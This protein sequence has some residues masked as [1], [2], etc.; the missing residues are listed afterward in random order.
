MFR[1]FS[2]SLLL[3]AFVSPESSA[4]VLRVGSWN[5]ANEPN[6]LERIA[7]FETVLSA[8]GEHSV[9]GNS[10]RLSILALQE[11]DTDSA[12]DVRDSFNAMY[13]GSTY[14]TIFSNPDGGGDRTGFIYDSSLVSL[15][16]QSEL[17]DSLTHNVLRA[18]F[19]P[20]ALGTVEPLTVYSIHLKSGASSADRVIRGSEAQFIRADA[21]FLGPAASILFTGD[22]NM[23]SSSEAAWDNLTS[24][25]NA[26]A[27]DLADS[28]G[29]W[30]DNPNFSWLHTQAPGT[31]VDDRFDLQFATEG[32][33]DSDG[34]DFY[35]GSFTVFGNNGTHGLN[36]P[37]T[38]GTATDSEILSALARTSDHLPIFSDFVVV[39]IPEPG[40]ILLIHSGVLAW[41]LRRRRSGKS[42]IHLPA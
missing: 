19:A 12:F 13:T 11:T 41:H 15:V 1:I 27:F 14:Q 9:L 24:V 5:V 29:D 34:L 4:Q 40:G 31:Q 36:Q 17:S 39:A 37:I 10:A 22:F 32:L 23:Q 28:P 33:F 42:P 6:S 16:S 20:T 21:D 3:L 8:I 30:R 26:Q 7:D 2:I 38:T 25:G 35:D 18:T